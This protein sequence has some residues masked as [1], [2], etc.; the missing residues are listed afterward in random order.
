MT[1]YDDNDEYVFEFDTSD[2][3]TGS[4]NSCFYA[5]SYY[6]YTQWKIKWTTAPSSGYNGLGGTQSGAQEL[7]KTDGGYLTLSAQ[8]GPGMNLIYHYDSSSNKWGMVGLDTVTGIDDPLAGGTVKSS[9]RSTYGYT[10]AYNVKI[11]AD[12]DDN[13]NAFTGTF[14]KFDFTNSYSS[15]KANWMCVASNGWW[16]FFRSSN[17]NP[18]CTSGYYYVY[19][20][21]YRWSGFSLGGGYYGRM[22][23]SGEVSYKVGKVAPEPDLTGPSVDHAAMQDSHSTKRT[24]SFGIS[25]GGDPPAGLNTSSAAGVGPTMYYTLTDANGNAGSQQT[26]VLT[27]SDTRSNC[28]VKECSWST[29]LSD[30]DRGSTVSYYVRAEDM[31]TD[32]NSGSNAITTSAN[33]FEIGDP[34]KVL[35]VEWHDIGFNYQ[36]TCNVQAKFYDVTNEIEFHYDP[37]CEA[38]YDYATVGYQDQTRSKGA[39]LR[40]SL[41][42][43]GNTA[44]GVGGNPHEDNYRIFTSSSSHGSETFEPGSFSEITNYKTA[45]SGTSNGNPYLY[46][47]SSTY[48]WN[49]YKANCDA[50]VDMPDD[51]SFEYFGTTYDGSSSNNRMMLSRFAGMYFK[52]TSSTSPERAMTTWYSNMP[53]LPYSSNV[54]ARPGLIA[55]WWGGYSTYY[56]YDNSNTDCS[57]RYRT[58]PFEGKGTDIDADIN[59]DTSWD[60]VDSPIRINPSGDYL[61]VNANLDIEEG[62]VVRVAQGKGISFDS[63]CSGFTVS[64]KDGTNA[65]TG[66]D[67]GVLFEG[68]YGQTWTGIAFTNSCSTASGTDDRH[69]FTHTTFA[70]TTDY[71]IAAGSRHGSSPSSNANVGNFTMEGVAFNNVAGAVSHGSGQGTVF[72]ITDFEVNDASESC[73]HFPGQSVVSLTEGEMD[74]CNSGSASGEGAVVSESGSGGSLFMENVTVTDAYANLVNV[75]LADVTMNNITASGGSGNLL[76]HTGSGHLAMNNVDSSGYSTASSNAV[77]FALATVTSDATLALTPNGASATSA[78]PS[79]DD[80]TLSDVTMASL[81]VARSAVTMSDVDLGSGDLVL[82]GNSLSADQHKVSDLDAGG[83]SVSG[84]GYNIMLTN[85]ALDDTSDTA[86]VSSSCST[87]SAPNRIWINDG[88]IDSGSS[89]DNILYARNSEITVGDVDITGQTA[90]GNNVALASTNGVI[91]MVDVSW[92]GNECTDSGAWAGG[93]TCWVAIS[94]SSGQINFGGS[95]TAVTFKEKSGARTNKAGISVSTY[96]LDSTGAAAT[97]HV[98][99]QVTDSNGEAEVWTIVQELSGS[100]LTSTAIGGAYFDASGPAGINSTLN[101]TFAIDGTQYLRLF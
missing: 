89:S 91:T 15:S 68:Q 16:Y 6:F 10:K 45:I 57:V 35:I 23:T 69:S 73:F 26:K 60:I 31:S 70:N 40:Q 71:A 99:T 20:N 27:P 80:A 76:V 86:Y 58:M 12:V 77:S 5:T 13:G 56:C 14:G 19:S 39:T 48:Y 2:C 33:S 53:D 66:A 88:T 97:Y 36:Y 55:P 24:F 8:H 51:F 3:G 41:G 52:Q 85:I 32:N 84:C 62:V 29:T 42:Y 79:G 92:R 17:S 98:G 21:S 37:D 81:S 46:Y 1:Y 34:N 7:H 43:M 72:D 67:R 50:N 28:E 61:S 78:G 30:M 18:I 95:G 49:S 83:I 82:S 64:G 54:A 38:Y 65:T 4:A 75:A 25:D 94:S 9:H 74:G 11:P 90:M 44:K 96:A 100:S 93:S 87:S 101:A 63:A 47:C 22:A 59:T